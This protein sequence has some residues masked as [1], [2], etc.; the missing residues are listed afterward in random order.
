MVDVCYLELWYIEATL[1]GKLK[2]VIYSL[3]ISELWLIGLYIN[4]LMGEYGAFSAA[5][6]IQTIANISFHSVPITTG[7]TEA[8]WNQSFPRL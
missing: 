5:E 1:K 4:Y 6:A 7:W 8:V 3:D 2:G